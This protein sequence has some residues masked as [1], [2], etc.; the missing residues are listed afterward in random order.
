MDFNKCVKEVEY[1]S[2]WTQE[3]LTLQCEYDT[4]VNGGI[5]LQL[6]HTDEDGFV[7]HYVTASVCVAG[8]KDDEIAIKDYSENYGMYNMLLAQGVIK[9]AH[10]I[11]HQGFVTI[12]VCYL[13][14]KGENE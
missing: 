8:L 4:Y 1:V 3:E 5:A 9:P 10:R 6:C 2:P 12:P 7:E 14:E 13:V 11:V